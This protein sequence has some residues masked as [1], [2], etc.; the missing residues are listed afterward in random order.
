[1]KKQRSRWCLRRFLRMVK[2]LPHRH[3]C[4]AGFLELL[5]D[6]IGIEIV[7]DPDMLEVKV[8]PFEDGDDGSF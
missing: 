6:I 4:L 2:V 8:D 1:M 7:P 5:E 3:W